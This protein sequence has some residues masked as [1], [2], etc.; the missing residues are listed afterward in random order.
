LA[1]GFLEKLSDDDLRIAAFVLHISG[2]YGIDRESARILSATA[3]LDHHQ[4]TTS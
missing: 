3:I 1:D 2:R 4:H